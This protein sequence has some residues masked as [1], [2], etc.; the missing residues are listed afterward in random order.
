MGAL[1]VRLAV[2]KREIR[3]AQRLRYKVFFQDGSATPD[4]RAHLLRRDVCRFDA[5]CDHLIVVDHAHRNRMGRPK[6]KVV[7]AYRLLRQDV[8]ERN[9]GFYSAGEFDIAPLLARHAGK[10][11]LELGRSCVAPEYRSKRTLELLWRGLWAY[12]C[13]HKIDCMIGCASFESIEPKALALP[14]SFLHHHALANEEWRA[15]ALAVR[16]APMDLL[17][18][19]AIDARR[20]MQTLPPL[21]KGYLRA[22]A[23]VGS[24]AVVDLQFGTTDV[25][26]VLPVADVDRRYS[27]HFSAPLARAA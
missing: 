25:L 27:G 11:F 6:P 26:I 10:Q 24:G 4:R 15:D 8:A 23:R 16:L 17:P 14:L 19:A 20:A 1:E 2:T 13:H 9:F 5:I 21:I 22:G 12:A 18:R 3:K 7:G